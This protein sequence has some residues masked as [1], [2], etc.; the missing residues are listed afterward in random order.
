MAS[1]DLI[2]EFDSTALIA[3]NPYRD[4]QRRGSGF[5]YEEFSKNSLMRYG[6]CHAKAPTS[7]DHLTN[8]LGDQLSL[9][10]RLYDLVIPPER[11]LKLPWLSD[12]EHSPIL[13]ASLDPAVSEWPWG[14]G[15][16]ERLYRDKQHPYLPK[17]ARAEHVEL[18]WWGFH[19]LGDDYLLHH[20]QINGQIKPHLSKAQEQ[21]IY[22]WMLDWFR[23][24]APTSGIY[25]PT[26]DCMRRYCNAKQPNGPYFP[27][28][29]YEDRL[30]R[31]RATR[32]PLS[33][34]PS[35]FKSMLPNQF[36]ASEHQTYW[37]LR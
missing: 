19:R 10:A 28:R 30:Y 9:E 27:E 8:W 3:A 33:D 22:A 34:C 7:V 20:T 4:W 18:L 1:V 17:V 32:V 14:P 6:L 2:S 12:N 35:A 23:L 11:C 13:L 25:I 24:L 26:L 16:M 21:R 36:I 15:A 5:D 29:P 37:R 31:S